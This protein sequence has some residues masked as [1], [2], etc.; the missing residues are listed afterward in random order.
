MQHKCAT[1]WTERTDDSSAA[2]RAGGRRAY[3]L[4]RAAERKARMAA[5]ATYFVRNGGGFP[6]RGGAMLA[7]LLGV[8]RSTICRDLAVLNG[9]Q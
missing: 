9:R 2:R 4:R 3:N 6:W 8:S 5:L 1:R 7:E